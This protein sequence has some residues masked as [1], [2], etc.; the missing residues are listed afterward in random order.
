MRADTS[1]KKKNLSFRGTLRSVLAV[2]MAL[3]FFMGTTDYFINDS[4][5][6]REGDPLPHSQLLR[7][8][9]AEKTCSVSTA[10]SCSF[11]AV[12]FGILPLKE[13]QVY[14]FG[15]TTLCPGGM[16]FGA[17]MFTQGLLVVGFTEIDCTDG[18]RQPAFDAGIRTKD[19]ILEINGQPI[20][21]A[22]AMA[23]YVGTCGGS[24]LQVKLRRGEDI[25][26]LPITPSFSVS[27][28]KY[29]TG[30]WVRDNT[31]GIGTVTFIDPQTG[32]FAGLGHGICD[33]SS[34]AL[35][36]LSRGIIMDVTIN[37]I[38]KGASGIPGELKG[39]FSS[40]KK[41][42]L[43]GNSDAGV[44]GLLSELPQGISNDTAIPIAL[45]NEIRDGKAQIY[46]T[47]DESGIHAY[48]ITVRK[49]RNSP[50]NKNMEI[51]V[52]DPA[53]IE[54]TGGIV[55]GMSGSPIIQDGKL[56]GA[57]THV[58]INDPCR[59]YGIYIENMLNAAG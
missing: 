49:I 27:E 47:L 35:L 44:F 30:M 3:S 7:I 46:C 45:K 56:V 9:A 36:P 14:S 13:V 51:T 39:Y 25:L 22:E 38:Q 52:I 26:T 55:Q 34:G 50:D 59:G 12:L 4:Y 53:L 5:S 16:P 43:V 10:S 28:N 37:G 17:K 8:T 54:K 11:R 18:S 24:T 20:N 31:A 1:M 48:D 32:A 58:L 19:I 42:T 41:G 21:G 2:F 33:S 15:N 6:R 29:K 23:E 40:G 57:V